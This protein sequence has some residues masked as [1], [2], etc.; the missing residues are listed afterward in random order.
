MR[1]EEFR[2]FQREMKNS[3]GA[4]DGRRIQKGPMRDDEFRRDQ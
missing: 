1:N 2:R 4:Y 3:E